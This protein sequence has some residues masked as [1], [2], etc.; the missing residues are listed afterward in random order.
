MLKFLNFTVTSD[1]SP[2]KSYYCEKNYVFYYNLPGTT[3]NFT[4]KKAECSL[5]G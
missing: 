4:W 5:P 3:I 1:F 2:L